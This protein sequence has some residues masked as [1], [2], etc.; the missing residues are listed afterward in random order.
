MRLLSSRV[1]T[2]QHFQRTLRR[3][4]SLRVFLKLFPYIVRRWRFFAL[5]VIFMFISSQLSVLIPS[6]SRRV[7]DEGI[8]VGRYEIIPFQ[9]LLILLITLL[10]SVFNYFERCCSILFS[11]SIVMDL[12]N[13]VFEAVQKQS[14][15]FFDRMPTGQLISRITNDTDRMSRFLSFQ[16]RT[17]ISSI[18]LI[19][20]SFAYMLQM[21]L[22]LATLSFLILPIMIIVNLRYSSLIRPIYSAIRHQVGVLTSIVNNN[23]VG[24]RTIKALA[25]E[26]VEFKRFSDE[27]EQ[28][29][30]LSLKAS[31]IRS[32]YGYSSSLIIGIGLTIIL[33]YG[34]NS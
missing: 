1:Y 23:V 11:Q 22:K 30:Q 28:L 14:F 16:L 3:S 9:V 15:A 20:L 7:I 18:V 19:S 4:E 12:R 17:L 27:N 33:F 29:F 6:I 10:I 5:S 21:N 2:Q 13:D 34:G 25:V 32:I 8:I 31:K 26:D 24:I